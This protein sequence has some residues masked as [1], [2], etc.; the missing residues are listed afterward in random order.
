MLKYIPKIISPDLMKALMEMGHGDEIVIVDGNFPAYSLG[1]KT[2]RIDGVNT[3]DLMKTILK[4]FPLDQYS[5]FNVFFMKPENEDKPKIWEKYYEVLNNSEEEGK[6]NFIPRH[7]FY[8][9]AKKGFAVVSTSDTELYA[10]FILKK[11]VC[12]ENKDFGNES[13]K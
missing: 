10:C 4:F 7:K 13:K 2:I 3:S 5:D 1:I 12:I 8:E 11:G 9:R 6:V